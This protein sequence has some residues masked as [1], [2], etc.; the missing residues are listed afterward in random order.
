MEERV[1]AEIAGALEASRAEV[2]AELAAQ[3]AVLIMI[4]FRNRLWR[5]RMLSTR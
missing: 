3:I 5:F 1:K 4:Y 2:K